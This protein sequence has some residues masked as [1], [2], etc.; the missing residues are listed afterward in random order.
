MSNG[1]FAKVG[2]LSSF[3]GPRLA[4]TLLPTRVPSSPPIKRGRCLFIQESKTTL[5]RICAIA[6]VSSLLA[7]ASTG[8]QSGKW[9]STC[10]MTPSNKR[11]QHAY[12]GSADWCR[13]ACGWE[14]VRN[15]VCEA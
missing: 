3:M 14:P 12:Q 1:R 2:N 5:S 15:F 4:F 9:F 11:L 7:Q 6:P 10:P 13:V 8:P